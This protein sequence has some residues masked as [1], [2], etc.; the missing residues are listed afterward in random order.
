MTFRKSQDLPGLQGPPRPIRVV[1]VTSRDAGGGAPRALYRVFSCLRKFEANAVSVSMRVVH[2]SH[3]ESEIIGG[4]PAR[5]RWENLVYLARTRYRKYFPRKPFVTSNKALHAPALYPTGLGRE[6]NRMDVDVVLVGW[7][8][9]S[10]LSV[11]EIGRIRK[12]VVFRLSD[13]WVFCGAEH[14]TTSRRY[15]HG[16]SKASRPQDEEGPDINRETFRRKRRSWKNPSHIVALSKWQAKEAQLSTLTA[17]WPITTIP[18]P[19]DP[20]FWRPGSKHEARAYFGIPKNTIVLLFGA[21]SG[22][23]RSEKGGDLFLDSLPLIRD[24]HHKSGDRRPLYVALFGEEGPAINQDGIPVHRLGHLGDADLVQAYSATDVFIVPS[25]LEAFGQVA[26]EAQMCG[27][28]VVAFR[29]TG[30]AD[31]VE[32]RKTGRLAD[33]MSAD[34]LAHCVWWT[35]EEP[36][37]N[38]DLGKEARLRAEKIWNPETVAAQYRS[39]FERALRG[40]A[41]PNPAS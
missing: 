35:V 36:E 12:P 2:K 20:S 19:V 34:D 6:I 16:Y 4:K 37:R 9:N 27:R 24:L 38:E 25:R 23:K 22:R 10:T 32:N 21:G 13:M 41:P 18:V 17:N 11:E 26:A 7:L 29:D 8:G 40:Q 15:V 30:L 28:P 31:V 39:V 1:I 3:D 33:Q 5:S 14:Y